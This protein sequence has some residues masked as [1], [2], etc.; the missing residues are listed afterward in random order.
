MSALSGLS[1]FY[2]LNIEFIIVMLDIKN[3]RRKNIRGNSL[4]PCHPRSILLGVLLIFIGCQKKFSD[5]DKFV[6]YINGEESPFVKTISKEGVKVTVNFLPADGLL[7]PSYRKLAKINS[8]TT[9]EQEKRQKRKEKIPHAKTQRSQRKNISSLEKQKT[10]EKIREQIK[11][12]KEIYN[13]SLYFQLTIGY[14]DETKDIVFERMKYGFDQYSEWL[15]KLAFR[16]KEYIYLKTELID[17]IP[18]DTY[19]MERTFGM[20]K[21]RKILIMFPKRFNDIDLLNGDNEYIEL[22]MDEFGL[23]AG[24]L[25]FRFEMPIEQIILAIE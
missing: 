13:R 10:K 2:D 8:D 4:Y 21:Y 16:L 7:I 20:T 18:V 6:E 22:V 12:N 17:E 25:R 5:V 9:L 15:Q 11:K 19:H 14:E 3:N 1:V 24:K 23:G